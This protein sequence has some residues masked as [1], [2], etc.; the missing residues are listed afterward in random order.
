[1]RRR[2]KKKEVF[3]KQERVS[4]TQHCNSLLYVRPL[5]KDV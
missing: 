1:M 5:R 3:G 2:E 4:E